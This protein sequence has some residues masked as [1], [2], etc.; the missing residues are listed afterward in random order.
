MMQQVQAMMLKKYKPV[1]FVKTL[2]GTRVLNILIIG[3]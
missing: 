2:Q 3:K 1:K